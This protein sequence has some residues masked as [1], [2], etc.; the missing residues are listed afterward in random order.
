[1]NSTTITNNTLEDLTWLATL[2]YNHDRFL[3]HLP[4]PFN[5][6]QQNYHVIKANYQHHGQFYHQSY[7]LN[8]PFDK[9]IISA[10]TLLIPPT[11]TNPTNTYIMNITEHGNINIFT[12]T[13]PIT[14]I[15][16]PIPIQVV[17]RITNQ[18]QTQF[19]QFLKQPSNVII[20][21]DN[22]IT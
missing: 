11:N 13:F 17:E 2:K 19:Q 15:I 9:T 3:N 5:F 6:D 8:Y 14:S 16:E 12:L 21:L 10:F 18:I 22:I 20:N 7:Q 1:M 4:R